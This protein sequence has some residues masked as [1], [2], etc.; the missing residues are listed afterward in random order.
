MNAFQEASHVT[1]RNATFNEV[2]G[3]QTNNYYTTRAIQ[4]RER[5]IYD[6]FTYVK[7]GNVYIIE[8]IH[9]RA[10]ARWSQGEGRREETRFRA[11][12]T[13]CTAEIDGKPGRFTAMS[14]TGPEA[15]EAWE[16]DFRHFSQ[17]R[18]VHDF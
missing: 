4:E 15:T 5:T 18:W 8:D 13:I 3:N 14:Y 6:E 17:A 7:L 16:E 10:C 11:E 2:G 12:R 9:R 1:I